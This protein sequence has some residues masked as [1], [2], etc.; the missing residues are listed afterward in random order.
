MNEISAER[1]G[2]LSEDLA[3]RLLQVIDDNIEDSDELDANV[4]IVAAI[5]VVR[6]LLGHITC[7]TCRLTAR[8]LIEQLMPDAIE[9]AMQQ[10]TDLG[11]HLH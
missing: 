1:M 6:N 5:D 10:P 3:K 4:A 7:P 2:E 9:D 8:G 11:P